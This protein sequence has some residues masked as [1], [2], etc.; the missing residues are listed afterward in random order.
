MRKVSRGCPVTTTVYSI[1]LI[2]KKLNTS[3]KRRSW[4]KGKPIRYEGASR[5]TIDP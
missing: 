4:E 1:L 5:R 2:R 3:L